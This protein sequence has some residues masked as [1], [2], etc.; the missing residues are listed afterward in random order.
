MGFLGLKSYIRNSVLAVFYFKLTAAWCL[1]IGDLI[2]GQFRGFRNLNFPL[3]VRLDL[4]HLV[5]HA[6]K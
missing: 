5:F 4:F 3:V 2:Y 1:T 6:L